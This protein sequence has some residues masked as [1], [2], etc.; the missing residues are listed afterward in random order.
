[1]IDQA[2]GLFRRR[3]IGAFSYSAQGI[4]ACFHNEEAFRVEVALAF[5]LI[6]IGLWLGPSGV[7]K[8]LLVS[9]VV[10]VL[11]V[12]LLNSAVECAIDRISSDFSELAGRAKDQGSAAVFIS[13]MLVLVVW[14]LVLVYP[15]IA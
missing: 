5:F 3:I 4:R 12:E 8:A 7:D 13:M 9:S 1:M 14:F 2:A 6:P 11:I 10:L 15:H